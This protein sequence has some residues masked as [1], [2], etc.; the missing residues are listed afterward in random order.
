MTSSRIPPASV[1]QTGFLSNAA[2]PGSRGTL[3]V[4]DDRQSDHAAD[5][6]PQDIIRRRIAVGGNRAILEG[7]MNPRQILYRQG[8][9]DVF[10]VIVRGQIAGVVAERQ[11]EGDEVRLNLAIVADRA[12]ES[13]AAGIAARGCALEVDVRWNPRQGL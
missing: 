5:V 3:P 1:R 8:Q 6:R 11:I 2:Y 10:Q 4:L 7:R 13:T 9:T 12:R